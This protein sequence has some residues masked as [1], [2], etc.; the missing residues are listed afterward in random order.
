LGCKSF[1]FFFS[2]FLKEFNLCC[3]LKD[4]VSHPWFEGKDL[5]S[6][7]STSLSVF[8]SGAASEASQ[9]S[10]IRDLRTQIQQLTAVVEELR[11]QNAELQ[12]RLRITQE[13]L[14]RLRNENLA[15]T[16]QFED[17]RVE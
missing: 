10:I 7:A 12:S 2:F 11:N 14:E 6:S 17:Y 15:F 16:L 13:E 4:L 3:C 8:V 1:L 5:T 9:E